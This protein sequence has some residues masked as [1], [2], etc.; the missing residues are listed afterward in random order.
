[1]YENLTVGP[2]FIIQPIV[3]RGNELYNCVE[4]GA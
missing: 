1:M 2:F 4:K 3:L